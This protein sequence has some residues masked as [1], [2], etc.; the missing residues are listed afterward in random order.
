M[1]RKATIRLSFLAV[2]LVVAGGAYML[3]DFLAVPPSGFD[4]FA[5]SQA[6]TRR[7]VERVRH[8]ESFTLPATVT[9]S[10]SAKARRG[11]PPN[12][13]AATR[14]KPETGSAMQRAV[15]ELSAL[16]QALEQALDEGAP[17]LKRNFTHW[18]L[19]VASEREL[20]LGAGGAVTLA[21]AVRERIMKQIQLQLMRRREMRTPRR[22]DRSTTPAAA[23]AALRLRLHQTLDK[24][25]AV[26]LT[27]EWAAATP[28]YSLNR[29][30][31]LA[32]QRAA[33][34]GEAVKTERLLRSLLEAQHLAA[35]NQYAPRTQP[36]QVF[37]PTIFIYSELQAGLT[38]LARA[39]ALPAAAFAPAR[40]ILAAGHLT[41]SQTADLRTDFALRRR[42]TVIAWL[43]VPDYSGNSWHRL[44]GGFPE[45][46]LNS[47]LEPRARRE[48][49]EMIMAWSRN[50]PAAVAAAWRD[51]QRTMKRMNVSPQDRAFKML[52]EM[53]VMERGV[54]APEES[55][56][57]DFARLFLAAAQFRQARGRI[58]QSP[59]EMI[60]E[61]ADREFAAPPDGAWAVL[62]SPAFEHIAD[63]DWNAPV[64]QDAFRWWMKTR[65]PNGPGFLEAIK[66]SPDHQKAAEAYRNASQPLPERPVICRLRPIPQAW[67]DAEFNYNFDYN[68][69][70]VQQL[71]FPPGQPRPQLYAITYAWPDWGDEEILSELLK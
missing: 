8:P 59:A 71:Y 18:G 63:A 10:Q 28:I 20:A 49:D 19:E 27:P 26:L 54:V 6:E 36:R 62:A 14:K 25:E 42:D 13:S 45:F 22:A 24:T 64:I 65:T 50:D 41:T 32:I 33:L 16:D 70:D 4:Q 43:H 47:V 29:L 51:V 46:C 53:S 55:L 44:L 60:P 40:R 69:R 38:H 61:A 11:G 56:E 30:G 52:E 2:L 37:R 23:F 48:A 1:V 9:W 57:V 3:V 66:A 58:P 39:G 17:G 12:K 31:S 21:P 7:R 68:F 15:E 35:I 34:R 67:S 5:A